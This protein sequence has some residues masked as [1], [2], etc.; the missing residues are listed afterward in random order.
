M[1]MQLNFHLSREPLSLLAEYLASIRPT[2]FLAIEIELAIVASIAG[3]GL[4]DWSS[5][6][7]AR[8]EAAIGKT[9]FLPSSIGV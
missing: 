5:L 4:S 7:A 2:I 1:A 6:R 8:I 3:Q 9:R